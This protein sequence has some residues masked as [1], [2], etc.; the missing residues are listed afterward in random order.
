MADVNTVG[1]DQSHVKVTFE[2]RS[3]EKL[4]AI[5]FKAMDSELGPYLMGKPAQVSVAGTLKNDTWGG[6]TRT[7]LIIDDAFAG[8]WQ[9]D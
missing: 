6:R 2:N 4:D 8:T 7:Q 9:A 1:K 3:G 5:A